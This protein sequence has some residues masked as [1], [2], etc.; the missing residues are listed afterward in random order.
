MDI[1]RRDAERLVITETGASLRSLVV[2]ATVVAM[3]A[4]VGGMILDNTVLVLAG[5]AVVLLL[6]LVYIFG[7]ETM[8]ADLD[9]ATGMAT[10]QRQRRGASTEVRVQIAD[11]LPDAAE[12]DL[13]AAVQRNLRAAGA[14][15]ITPW[16]PTSAVP[17]A[18]ARAIL[19]WSRSGD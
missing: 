15:A 8:R 6:Y 13:L 14:T 1:T 9:R 17:E 7:I 5:A 2:G 10:I 16:T 18:V 4:T 3:A 19:V 11:L 12:R